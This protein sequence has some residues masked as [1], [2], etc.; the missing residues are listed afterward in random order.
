MI[1]LDYAKYLAPIDLHFTKPTKPIEGIPVGNG[2]MGTLVWVD[3]SGSKLQFNFGRPDVFY[4]GS[5]T[6]TW[7]N[8]SHTDGNPKVGH[9][10][11]GFSGSPF[12]SICNQDL[13]VY[14][15]YESVQGA[16]VSVRIVPWRDRD[17]FAIEITDNRAAPSAITVDLK[18]MQPDLTT[19]LYQ[20][21]ATQAQQNKMLVLKQVISET[22][23]TGMSVNDFYCASACVIAVQGRTA[24]ATDS[25][26][27]I[28]AA[29]GTFTITIGSAASMTPKEDVVELA[30]AEVKAALA[31]T[32]NA[33]FDSNAAQWHDFWQ[34]SFIYLPATHDQPFDE[35]FVQH[36][37]YYL[38]GM[39]TCNRGKYPIHANGGIFNV[40]DGWQYWGSMYW[41]F[42]SSRQ[43]LTPVFEQANHPE[44]AD[45]YFSM[46]SRQFLRISQAAIQQWGAGKEA[47]YIQET[48]GFDGPEVLPD[49]IAADL[50][51][52]L[53]N[54]A[55]QS[56]ALDKFRKSRSEWE[57]RWSMGSGSAGYHTHLLYNTAEAAQWYWERYE[58]TGD[59]AWLKDRAYP[60]LKGAAELYRTHPLTKLEADGFYHANNL[61]WA[62]TY[63]NGV[64]DGIN[65]LASIRGIFPVAIKAAK[66][67]NTDAELV[68]LWQ[69]MLDKLAPYPTHATP[70]A[71]GVLQQAGEP[72][73]AIGV[74]SHSSP[75][76]DHDP[77]LMMVN[78]FDLVNT[79]SKLTKP[80][81]WQM[82]M[83]TLASLR[84]AKWIAMNKNE[85]ASGGASPLARFCGEAARLG[86]AEWVKRC[87][88]YQ[89]SYWK[90]CKDAPTRWINR[91]R[92]YNPEGGFALDWQQE[93]TFSE[94]MSAALLQS[95]AAAPG[96]TPV[97]RVFPAWPKD[98]D[99]SFSL[100]AKGD[101]LVTSM[102]KSGKVEFIEMT[103][104]RG[105][106]C[107]L[108]NAW[109]KQ[110]VD[111][112]R[113]NKESETLSVE[114]LTFDTK[115]NENIVMVKSGTKPADFRVTLPQ[116]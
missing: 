4:M 39:N 21:T 87:L 77:R 82:A 40:Q 90:T 50:K 1:I 35:S 2:N 10:E 104:L 20:R 8:K 60:M 32:F 78:V 49:T 24:T 69:D 91:I 68:P 101:F 27:T 111:L 74:G 42:N 5:A 94:G 19:N 93:A 67:L 64:R 110:S 76:S 113:N 12:A 63:R 72:V 11:I 7:S 44:L 47:I 26:L 85:G 6:T 48:F 95:G 51:N 79:E 33:I 41:W 36:W 96:G 71:M 58:Y 61:G 106:P 28:P 14:D 25:Q 15:G 83:N 3:G 112:Y 9:V 52:T 98:M 55:G 18:Q 34:K 99:A 108:R 80:D 114:L 100:R 17:V 92:E 57:S 22:C 89:Q 103:S 102:L 75:G 30:V 54:N 37:L 53:V 88:V 107:T 56:Q 45:P 31:T 29:K 84:Q 116:S 105:G 65:D 73:F 16:E 109:G 115:K 38:Y 59:L 81:E 43:T 46:L 86:S 97:I 70:Q 23:S 13:H 62:E 66:L